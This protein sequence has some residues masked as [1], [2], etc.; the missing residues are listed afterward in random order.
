MSACPTCGQD[1]GE[2]YE[3][4]PDERAVTVWFSIAAGFMV[5]A[6]FPLVA[7]IATTI[8]ALL[9]FYYGFR[10]RGQ[11]KLD[12]ALEAERSGD[13]KVINP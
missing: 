7:A 10:L 3:L 13:A 12:A 2:S 1:T 5:W 6:I 4:N 8:L 9:G 11:R